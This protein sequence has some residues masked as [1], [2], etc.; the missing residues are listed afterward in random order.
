MMIL[1]KLIKK[2]S[3]VIKLILE[4]L[5]DRNPVLLTYLNQY[6]FNLYNSNQEYRELLDNRFNVFPDGFGVYTA[7][8]FLGYKNVQKFNATDLYEKLFQK[9]SVNRTKLFLIG[10][11]FAEEFVKLKAAE[12][13]ITVCGYRNGYNFDDNLAGIIKYI[14]EV[15]PDAFVIGMGIP[16]QE[17]LAAKISGY[18]KDVPVICVGAF[19]E[20][21]F[22]TKKRAPIILR[23]SGF[24]WLHRLIKEPGR[25]WKRYLIGIPLFFFHILRLKLSH[26]KSENF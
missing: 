24:E 6:C 20:F 19:L 14:S 5:N 26:S 8:N 12:K 18:F 9:F 10:G 2:E 13:M 25:L 3:E 22:G 15:K 17:F 21:Y 1:N 23:K 4:P 7:M 16:S 11:N